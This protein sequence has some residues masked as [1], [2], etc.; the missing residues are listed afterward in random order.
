MFAILDIRTLIYRS[1]HVHIYNQKTGESTGHNCSDDDIQQQS[2]DQTDGKKTKIDMV[3]DVI[4]GFLTDPFKDNTLSKVSE[5]LREYAK[6]LRQQETEI[7]EDEAIQELL[8]RFFPRIP[9]SI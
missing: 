6:N 4:I 3:G 5:K 7:S 1:R 2:D 8:E 9:V